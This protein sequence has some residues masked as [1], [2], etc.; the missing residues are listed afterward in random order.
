M[1]NYVLMGHPSSCRQIATKYW[2]PL[3]K[4]FG[5]SYRA[6][7]DS[8]LRDFLILELRPAKPF[9]LENA[10]AEFKRWYPAYLNRSENH[11]QAIGQLQ[12]MARFGRYYCHFIIGPDDTPQIEVRL[13]C[14]QQTGRR[15]CDDG[16]DVVRMH[17]LRQDTGF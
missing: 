15:S 7:F 14:L 4:A 1:R 5:A 9:K 11:D 8:F 17:A 3:E 10:H 12:R 16:D 6:L 13:A 2:R